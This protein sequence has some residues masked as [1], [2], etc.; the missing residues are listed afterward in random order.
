[1]GEGMVFGSLAGTM[2]AEMSL[3]VQNRFTDLYK[4]TRVSPSKRLLKVIRV[5]VTIIALSYLP[6]V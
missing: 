5:R 4:P 6:F 3:G 2:L 1:M